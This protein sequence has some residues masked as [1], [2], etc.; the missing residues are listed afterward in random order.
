MKN[1]WTAPVLASATFSELGRHLWIIRGDVGDTA[2]NRGGAPVKGLH[3]KE[4]LG[5]DPGETN[6]GEGEL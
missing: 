4:R 6:P 2:V 3:G 1:L 5:G